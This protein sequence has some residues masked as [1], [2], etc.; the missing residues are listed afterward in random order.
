LVTVQNPSFETGVGDAAF[1]PPA[2]WTTDGT[3]G[4]PSGGF[5]ERFDQIGNP[6]GGDMIRYAGIDNGILAQ[7]L[8]IPFQSNTRYTLTFLV[9]DRAGGP[10]EGTTQYGLKSS[11]AFAVDLGTPVSVDNEALPDGTFS[12][13]PAYTFVTGPVAPV[14]NVVVFFR[15][16]DDG[17]GNR[18]VVDLARLDATAIPEPAAAGLVGLAAVATLGRRRRAR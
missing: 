1:P 5:T 4:G 18:A 10:A 16:L 9:G 8:G 6:T 3:P 13:G 15:G 2:S 7:D 14:G 17:T 12:T 11:A